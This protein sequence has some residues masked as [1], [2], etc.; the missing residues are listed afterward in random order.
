[1]QHVIE[2][3]PNLIYIQWWFK[4]ILSSDG[5]RSV[6]YL[7]ALSFIKSNFNY[8]LRTARME[9]AEWTCCAFIQHFANIPAVII[10]SNVKW[11]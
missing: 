8:I 5:D 9:M 3:L 10:F 1:M 4:V 2:C 7:M 11:A 6:I